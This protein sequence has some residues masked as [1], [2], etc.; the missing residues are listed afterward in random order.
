[1]KYPVVV[2]IFISA[3]VAVPSVLYMHALAQQRSVPSVMDGSFEASNLG[4][5]ATRFYPSLP[6]GFRFK[7]TV[8]FDNLQE[9]TGPESRSM[10]T[11][12]V[13][14]GLEAEFWSNSIV[15]VPV[16]EVAYIR[17]FFQDSILTAKCERSVVCEHKFSIPTNTSVLC[18]DAVIKLDGA[19]HHS[20]N[21]CDST[22]KFLLLPKSIK[23]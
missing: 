18:L 9:L 20:A 4:G 1:M 12:N 5:Y 11:F 14:V 6:E 22:A 21:A 10:G 13:S 8:A 19:I 17:V 2:I 7:S 3:M 16:L 23:R 15:K